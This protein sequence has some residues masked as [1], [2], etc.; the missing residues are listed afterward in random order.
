LVAASLGRTKVTADYN[1]TP[2]RAPSLEYTT[3]RSKTSRSP[4]L[5]TVTK[6]TADYNSTPPRAPS[7]EYT[8]KRSKTSRS[9]ALYTVKPRR[10]SLR[11]N[12]QPRN[13]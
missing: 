2:P 4:A 8:T 3:K 12:F 7:L 13:I 6:V 10:R 1:S 11:D 9:P 5:Y